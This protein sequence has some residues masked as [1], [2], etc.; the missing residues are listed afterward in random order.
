[1]EL[2]EGRIGDPNHQFLDTFSGRILSKATASERRSLVFSYGEYK[3]K[4]R[5]HKASTLG[6]FSPT[7]A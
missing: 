7:H 5:L 4:K 3:S 2:I 6:G 1:M